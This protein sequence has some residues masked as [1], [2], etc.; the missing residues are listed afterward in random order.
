MFWRYGEEG[1]QEGVKG[2]D[3]RRRSLELE[4]LRFQVPQSFIKARSAQS[5]KTRVTWLHLWPVVLHVM[6][7]SWVVLKP[8]GGRTPEAGRGGSPEWSGLED[9][10]SGMRWNLAPRGSVRHYDSC[11]SLSVCQ[12]ARLAPSLWGRKTSDSWVSQHTTPSSRCSPCWPPSLRALPLTPGT[13][14]WPDLWSGG[15]GNPCGQASWGYFRTRL[16][17]AVL[18]VCTRKSGILPTP[19]LLQFLEHMDVS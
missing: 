7:E 3:S 1:C 18:G 11:L 2:K 10:D 12:V 17:S 5:C 8:G 6:V 19:F 9:Y 14:M 4:T 13:M 16:C 15:L